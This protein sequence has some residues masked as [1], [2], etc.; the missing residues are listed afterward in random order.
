MLATKTEKIEDRN[1][2]QKPPRSQSVNQPVVNVVVIVL[3]SF[4]ALSYLYAIPSATHRDTHNS[5]SALRCELG[6]F[7]AIYLLI[8]DVLTIIPCPTAALRPFADDFRTFSFLVEL[9]QSSQSL[10]RTHTL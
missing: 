3:L 1:R 2:R 9:L 8:Y 5:V 10:S 4:L 7:Q 6:R